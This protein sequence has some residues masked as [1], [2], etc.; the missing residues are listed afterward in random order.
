[1]V[2]KVK[3]AEGVKVEQ[4]YTCSVD[5][6]VEQLTELMEEK[7]VHSILGTTFLSVSISSHFSFF[8]FE[9]KDHLIRIYFLIERTVL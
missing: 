4:P 7:D 6:T 8:S 1:M 9:S 5:T 3:R 2:K